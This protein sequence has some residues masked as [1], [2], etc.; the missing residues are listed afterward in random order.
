MRLHVVNRMGGGYGTFLRSLMRRGERVWEVSSSDVPVNPSD[1]THLV[2]YGY[3]PD[4][5]FHLF[6]NA[7]RYYYFH[8]LRMLSCRM[9]LG[10]KEINP[11]HFWRLR[12]FRQWLRNFDDYLSVSF[13]MREMARKFYGVDSK[14]VHNG[15]EMKGENSPCPRISRGYLL[16]I[17]RGAWVKGLDTFLQLMKSLPEFEG[18]VVGNVKPAG[19]LP[20]VR[21]VGY[22]EDL[23]EVVCGAG[24]VVITS[25]F[26]SFS[27]TTL[28]ALMYGKPVL[29]LKRAAGAWE[30]L[31][32]LGLYRW[33]F[34][35]TDKIARFVR[36]NPSI[37]F[38]KGLDLSYFSFDNTYRKLLEALE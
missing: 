8:G 19:E 26:E 23:R 14:V 28:E 5:P 11:L 27:Y 32:M 20:N 30:I 18:V 25:Y 1:I 13:A 17:G 6:P 34:D 2:L 15:I 21:F 38:P 12:K 22:V 37:D 7:R 10:K 35:S 33:G 4:F 9:I 31:Q 36:E 16:W 29:V 24:A 3:M